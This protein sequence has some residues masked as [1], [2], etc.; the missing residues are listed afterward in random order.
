M[1]MG[2]CLQQA[3]GDPS[4]VGMGMA[5]MGM[6]GMGAAGHGCYP[7]SAMFGD[8]L[9]S[10]HAAA[11]SSAA[12]GSAAS[13]AHHA[14]AAHHQAA[15]HHHHHPHHPHGSASSPAGA[16]AAAA[17]AAHAHAA[18]AAVAGN[19]ATP[20]APPSSGY[21]PTPVSTGEFLSKRTKLQLY[22]C[23]RLCTYPSLGIPR[24]TS[25]HKQPT[26]NGQSLTCTNQ[27]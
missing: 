8:P 7:Y 6:A 9:G 19:G 21:S 17:A 10:L 18:A 26:C 24:T 23:R 13:R 12:Y 1:S 20:Q 3:R 5:G 25:A 14:A 2:S 15:A 16:A 27:L 22:R 11:A 4:A